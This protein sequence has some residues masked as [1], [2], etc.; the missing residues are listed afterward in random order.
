MSAVERGTWELFTTPKDPPN[1]KSNLHNE[2]KRSQ[3]QINQ[4]INQSANQS[5]ALF[6]VSVDKQS[7]VSVCLLLFH[8]FCYV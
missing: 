6:G 1:T 7:S 4:V 5:S 3:G 8:F 2:E